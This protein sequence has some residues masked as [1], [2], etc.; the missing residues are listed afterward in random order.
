M[1]GDCLYCGKRSCEH[2]GPSR[3][4]SVPAPASGR[5][6]IVR[7]EPSWEAPKPGDSLFALH[8]K[9]LDLACVLCHDVIPNGPHQQHNRLVHG[10]EH[11]RDGTATHSTQGLPPGAM[12]FEIA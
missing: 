4:Q 9:L 2:Q 6:E 12:R 3:A 5:G 1:S 7:P 10:F 8:G 11:V